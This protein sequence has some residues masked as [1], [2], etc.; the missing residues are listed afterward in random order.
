M[1]KYKNE[2]QRPQDQA[3]LPKVHRFI[4][5]PALL[6]WRHTLVSPRDCVRNRRGIWEGVTWGGAWSGDYTCDDGGVQEGVRGTWENKLG[7]HG[8]L[9]GFVILGEKLK[10]PGL[11]LLIY[12]N[13]FFVFIQFLLAQIVY[14][15]SHST[16]L[17]LLDVRISWGVRNKGRL[18]NPTQA[19]EWASLQVQLGNLHFNTILG[20]FF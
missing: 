16:R 4:Q 18:L 2:A 15:S 6:N 10:L 17:G 19:S 13:I 1:D 20:N 11:S 7:C 3:A 12:E 14:D 5:N 8:F 9:S